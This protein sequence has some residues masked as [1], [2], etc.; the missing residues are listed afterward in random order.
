MKKILIKKVTRDDCMKVCLGFSVCVLVM[1]L[2]YLLI[3]NAYN[4]AVKFWHIGLA[5]S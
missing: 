5:G 2:I 3:R 4:S 1:P